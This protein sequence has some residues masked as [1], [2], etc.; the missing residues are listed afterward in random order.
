MPVD[1]K[2][3]EY[4]LYES[5]W[6]K[7]R[8]A[9]EG[10]EAVKKGGQKY[11]PKVSPDQEID[12]YNAYK[13]R[14]LFFNA[15]DRTVQ[16][17]LGYLF[18]KPPI[19]TPPSDENFFDTAV[20][21]GTE[22]DVFLKSIAQEVLSVG[23]VGV[24]CDAPENGDPVLAKYK[25]EDIINWEVSIEKGFL[26]TQRVILREIKAIPDPE[27]EFEKKLIEQYR[28]LEIKNGVYQ[29]RIFIQNKET[30]TW[31]DSLVIPTRGGV[32]IDFIPFVFINQTNT[33]AGIQKPTLIDLVDVN[34]SHYRSS[35]DLEQGRHYTAL[36][37]PWLAGFDRKTI[38]AIGSGI[39]WVSENENAKAGFLEFTGQGLGALENALREKEAMMAVLGGRILEAQK[40]AVEATDTHKIKSSGEQSI[41]SS[42]ASTIDAGMTWICKVCADWR[43]LNSDKLDIEINKDYTVI[44]PDPPLVNILFSA[45]QGGAIS[46]ETWWYNLKK[47]ELTPPAIDFE[48]EMEL[49]KMRSGD[50]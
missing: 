19:L 4:Q 50:Q 20:I 44:T 1:T 45:L 12:R 7:C 17:L 27:D 49:I 2:H 46:A 22:F 14:A 9:I 48:T 6:L 38:A 15:T 24:I 47:Y 37:T 39:A 35:A 31:S 34:Y 25:T 8:T 21:S 5:E 30:N 16:S 3:A 32:T 23:R 11:L 41:L 18:R 10:E 28:V 13:K 26:E 40:Q 43:A 42:I 36:P 33:F 29:Q